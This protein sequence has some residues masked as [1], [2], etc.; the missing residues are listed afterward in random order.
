L[1]LI[2]EILHHWERQGVDAVLA[3]GFPMPAQKSGYSAWSIA[4]ISYTAV[5]NLLNFPAGTVPV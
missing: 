1:E 4:T 2:E 5:Y 3:P